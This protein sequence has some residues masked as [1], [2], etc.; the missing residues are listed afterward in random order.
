MQ[1]LVL[2]A[3]GAS[4][5]CGQPRPSVLKTQT[6]FDGKGNT[7]KNTIV[8]IEGAKIARLGGAPP[9]GA[10]TYDLTALT[11]SPGWIDT[12]SHL[13][14]HFD[15]SGRLSGAN[16]PLTQSLLHITDNL[17]LTLNAGFTTVQ[18]P[19]AAID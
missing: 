10:V 12:H 3:L 11:V 9:P 6:L 1:R 15:S 8:V 16:E 19:G 18:S 13:A 7:L 17:A 5:A 2:F 4:L 14:V